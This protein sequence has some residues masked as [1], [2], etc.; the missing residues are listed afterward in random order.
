VISLEEAQAHVLSLVDPLA[1]VAVPLDQ[2][3]GCAVAVPIIASEPVPGFANSSMDGF[4]LRSADTVDGPVRL[5]VVDRILAGRVS[6]LRVGPGD[7]MRIMTGAPLPAGADSVEM[8]EETEVEESG[9]VLALHRKVPQGAFVRHRGDDIEV[10]DAL[11]AAGEV[12]TPT[13]IGVLA[14]QGVAHVVAHPRPR[15]GVL[16]TGNELTDVPG[17]LPPGAIRDVNRPMLLSLLEEAGVSAVDLGVV[18]DDLE[19]TRQALMTAVQ[20]CDAVITTGG[21]SVGDV[22]FVKA[23]VTELGGASARS[24]QVAV[25]PGKPFAFGVVGPDHVPVFGLPGNPVSTRVSFELFVRP[26]LRRRGGHRNVD[27]FRADAVLDVNLERHP[28]GRVHMVHVTVAVGDDGRLHV[29]GA[30]REGSHLLHAV[31]GANAIA[32]VPDGPTLAVGTT[33]EVRILRPED[34]NSL[35]QG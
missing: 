22:D 11:I 21:V 33:V 27:R 17:E 14:S 16:S 5:R 13:R 9:A 31:A 19:A 32:T 12:L 29:T 3:L 34:L 7:A 8:I 15:V 26:S 18:R 2:A 20:S 10:G 1:P 23:A 25:R 24:M 35:R 30:T 6:D 28:D 4:A